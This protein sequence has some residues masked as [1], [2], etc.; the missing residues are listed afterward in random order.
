MGVTFAEVSMLDKEKP[1][2]CIAFFFSSN[3][4]RLSKLG[5]EIRRERKEEEEMGMEER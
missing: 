2:F 4:R 1:V 5:K 3:S